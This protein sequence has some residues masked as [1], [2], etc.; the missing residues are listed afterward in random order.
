MKKMTKKT[1]PKKSRAKPKKIVSRILNT[2]KQWSNK[3]DKLLDEWKLH[4]H[5][6]IRLHEKIL[7]GKHSVKELLNETVKM[8]KHFIDRVKKI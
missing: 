4:I 2:E 7:G 6:Q 5:E 1:H 8:E 3:L